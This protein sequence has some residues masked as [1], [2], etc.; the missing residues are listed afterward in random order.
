MEGPAPP[1]QEYWHQALVW[2]IL[3]FLPDNAVHENR[4]LAAKL[5]IQAP[6]D[7]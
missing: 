6:P 5:L 4:A 1:A 3:I 7:P 2:L